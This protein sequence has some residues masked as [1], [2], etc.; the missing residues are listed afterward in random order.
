VPVDIRYTPLYREA[1]ALYEALLRPGAGQICD[2]GEAHSSPNGRHAAFVGTLVH[3]LE[4]NL[5]TRICIADVSSG[6]T[7]V[8]TF[9]PNVDR[10]PKYS[11]DGRCL[12]FL[13]DRYQAGDF[14]LHL[15]D[16]LTGAVRSTS[17]VDGWVEYLHWSPDG[18]RIL[19][20]VAAHG[21]DI[22][23]AQGAIRSN[24]IAREVPAW[25]PAVEKEEEGDGW[26]SVW[27]YER[28]TGSLRLL[29][30]PGSNIWEAAW[31]GNEAIAAIASR[32]PREGSWY[33]A[34]LH[35]LDTRTGECR[36]IYASHAQ[37][38][39]PAGCPSA[40][41]VAFVEAICSD[42]GLAAGDLSI[43]EVSTRRSARLDTAGVN[44][45]HVEWRS[46]RC[47]LVAGHRAARTVIGLYD[48][49]SRAFKEVWSSAV[50]S[51]PGFLARVSGF[52][53]AGDCVLVAEG[54]SYAPELAVIRT[55]EYRTVRSFDVGYAGPAKA[56][57]ASEYIHWAAPDSLEIQGW[58][59]RPE[60]RGPHP[61]VMNIHGGPVWHWRPA[62]L[63][64]Q[65][66]AL[67]LM[68]LK[69]GYAVFLPNP[70]GSSGRGQDFVR[71][72][73]GDMGG[74][75]THDYLSG[76]DHLVRQGIADSNRLGVTGISYGGFMTCWLIT[77]DPRF[78]AAVP[79]APVS[80]RVS[81]RLIC[82]HAPFVD[83]FLADAYDNPEGKY[84]QRSPIM[85]AHR[86]KTPTLSIC[87]ALDR[88]TPPDQAVQFHNALQENGVKSMLVTYPEEGHGVRSFPAAIDY[89]ARVVGWFDDHL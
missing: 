52:G 53:E 60:G 68:L 56:I 38:G 54:F 67:I 40:T 73:V 41:H 51:T 36:E 15:L 77:Q 19:L 12:A 16:L 26:R 8:V 55:G 45:T 18:Q 29:S 43:I 49:E 1:E 3:A 66:T 81:Q 35:L 58:L 11:P 57:G 48:T 80:N 37:L 44:V 59:L 72:V 46:D 6:D 10:C 88:C 28:A 42:R 85:Y 50:V 65:R 78:A 84:F 62:W 83:L 21:A 22:A 4:G 71:L 23:G 32:S 31:C 87:G 24:E 47:I 39:W 25:I 14:Q 74:A 70:R 64:R 20:G 63:G 82:T 75:D 27:L 61:L 13:S 17:R 69:R 2:A 5:P 9:G 30:T 34:S 33:S 7:R 86:A 79:V 89:T 76:L